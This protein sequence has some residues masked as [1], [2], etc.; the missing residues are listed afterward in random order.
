[1]SSP[2]LGFKKLD[3]HVHTPASTDFLDKGVTPDQIVHSAIDAG[4]E[5]IAITDHNSGAWIDSVKDAAKRKNL[6]VF[7]GVEISCEGGKRGIH[8]IAIFDTDRD[9]AH[10]AGLL[11]RL[12]IPPER[13]GK[14]ESIASGTVTEVIDIVQSHEWCG[15]A[16]PAHVNS[17]KGILADMEGGQRTKLINH[18]GLI[19]V[20]AKCFD[21]ENLRAK[22]RR[23][24]DIFGGN[25]PDYPRRLAVYQASDNPSGLP[26][27]GHSLHSIGSTCA[28][29]K[30][31]Q[32]TL[33]SLRQCFLDPDVRIIQDF[34]FK[35]F[36]YPRIASISVD[37]G[38]FDGERSEFNEG[39]NSI[40]GGK[41]TGK[42]LLVELLRFGLNQ[43]PELKHIKQDHDKK[44][45]DRLG[46]FGVVNV[47]FIDDNGVLTPIS[48][49]YEPNSDG[50][51]DVEYDPSQVFPVLFLSQNEIIRIAEDKSLQLDFIDRFFPSRAF[52]EKIKVLESSLQELDKQLSAGLR[53][54][55][56]CA[57][58]RESIATAHVELTRLDTKLEAPIFRDYTVAENR[59]QAHQE[60]QDYLKNI[61]QSTGSYQEQIESIEFA[62]L[63]AMLADDSVLQT[64]REKL[65]EVQEFVT[66]QIEAIFGRISDV[67]SQLESSRL[68]ADKTFNEIRK[69][70]LEHVRGEGGDHTKLTGEREQLLDRMRQ[71]EARLRTETEKEGK[72]SSVSQER[73]KLLD[74]IDD[75]YLDW[76][77]TRQE[78][79][80]HFQASSD[81]K[82]ELNIAGLSDTDEFKRRLL[83]L[84][85]GSNLR[86]TDIAKLANSTQ[87]RRFIQALIEYR[88]R[89]KNLSNDSTAPLADLSQSAD[90]P[91]ERIVKLADFLLS[92]LDMERLLE[93]QY[94]AHPKDKPEIKVYVG[95]D[96]FESLD[97]VSVGQKCTAMLIMTLTDGY[98]PVVIDQPEDSLDIRSI[99]E[100]I[101]N[102]VRDKKNQRQFVFTT[103][104]S[105]VAVASDSDNFIILDADADSGRVVYSGSMDS[106]HIGDEVLKHLEGGQDPY[107]LKFLKYRADNR[108][109]TARN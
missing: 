103:H 22:K 80:D 93:V 67:E 48:R 104:N 37:G 74:Q 32:I 68:G 11:S 18:V 92:N 59:R 21:N 24:I 38:F 17:S 89:R 49:T 43:A 87:P 98:M 76:R 50:Y 20:E 7:P 61:S 31:Q 71:L 2:G 36:Q 102:K 75:V 77:R 15:I 42:S 35:R 95:N 81:G 40:L 30:M 100:D 64:N 46:H 97:S 19:A 29:F 16:I 26:Q 106:G 86:E 12:S 28:H 34:E 78:R 83:D 94:K 6:T 27:G 82:L 105:S 14:T 108:L 23:A 88:A 8:V 13:Q 33:E 69:K 25:H 51:K 63:Q 41:G 91:L 5:G 65:N 10:I 47:E 1:M 70:Y 57:V 54:G 60:Q 62:T 44:L 96:R 99:W 45:Q 9:S 39:L 66:S 85:Q 73:E 55:D 4:L 53:A 58:L 109:G 72:V 90:V 52:R 79:C 101:C 107:R 3:L 56:D 84:R